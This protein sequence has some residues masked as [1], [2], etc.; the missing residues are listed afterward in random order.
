MVEL[1]SIHRDRYGGLSPLTRKF[2]QL[3]HDQRI[4]LWGVAFVL[5]TLMFF[6]VFKYGPMVWAID[7]SFN[8]YDMVSPPR[9]IGLDNYRALLS[10]PIFRETLLN[11]FVYIAGSTVLTTVIALVLALAINTGIPGARYC[12][13]AMFLTNLMPIIAVMQ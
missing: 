3:D 11:T 8:S 9:F 2:W 5:P 4:R 12:M 1:T 13:T 7:L 6:A 10:D